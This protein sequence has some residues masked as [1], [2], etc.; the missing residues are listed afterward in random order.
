MKPLLVTAHLDRGFSSS[1]KWSPALDGILAYHH[2]KNKM[3]D[4]AFNLSLSMMEQTTVEDLPVQKEI[5]GDDWWYQCSCPIFDSSHNITRE[6]YKKFNI[7]A[8]MLIKQKAKSIE[9][10]KGQFKNYSL[11]FKEIITD[12]VQ[13]HVVGDE[14]KIR[15]LLGKCTQIGANRGKG[16]GVVT[17]WDIECDGD[18]A[19]ARFNRA[20]P[21][22]FAENNKK[23]GIK[24]WRGYRPSVRIDENQGICIL[25]L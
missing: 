25:P 1:D 17:R 9:L 8:S 2:L 4:E 23:V 12:K 24:I 20:L 22:G 14:E 16:M 19:Q 18:K 6:F 7:D 5:F 3:G 11:S 10:T 21:V 13:W 15:K